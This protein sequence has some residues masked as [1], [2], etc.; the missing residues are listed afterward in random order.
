MSKK[1]D[2]VLAVLEYF[3]TTDL[4]LAQ[5]ALS[6]VQQIV[7]RRGTPAKAAPPAASARL[8]ARPEPAKAPTTIAAV[9]DLSE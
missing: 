2:P 5:Q 3:Q 9:G 8:R 7:R 1:R 6:L 4:A